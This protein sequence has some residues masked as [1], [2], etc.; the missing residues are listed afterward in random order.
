[1]DSKDC[2]YQ[3]ASVDLG[4][5]KIS[6]AAF[7]RAIDRGF[8]FGASPRDLFAK[9][10]NLR[11]DQFCVATYGY[12]YDVPAATFSLFVRFLNSLYQL[13]SYAAHHV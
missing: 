12:S 2:F 5:L 10:R 3:S 4:L 11:F 8:H 1:M 13:V 9:F 6:F 7:S